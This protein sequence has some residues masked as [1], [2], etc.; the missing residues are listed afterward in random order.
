M[1]IAEYPRVMHLHTLGGPLFR[2]I[3]QF[4]NDPNLPLVPDD[5][6]FN[7]NADANWERRLK[8]LREGELR[9]GKFKEDRVFLRVGEYLLKDK[10]GRLTVLSHAQYKERVRNGGIYLNHLS[11]TVELM[12]SSRAN[13]RLRGE[14]WQAQ[15]RY[16]Y[17][18]KYIKRITTG[19]IKDVPS[20]KVEL[21][22]SQLDVMRAYVD[23]L[24]E[25]A[26]LE[27][28]EL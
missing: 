24:K 11:D 20:E 27:N 3:A 13:Q 23:V 9:L 16:D 28:I 14:F 4:A 17:L 19:K 7:T 2:H 22:M 18:D 1:D 15:L 12:N 10:N 8:A 21:L 26:S 6:S 5:P 25:R